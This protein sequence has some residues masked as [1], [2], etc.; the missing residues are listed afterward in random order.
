VKIKS[1]RENPA[2]IRHVLKTIS[3]RV[4]GTLITI[5]TAYSLGASLKLSSIL[6]TAEILIKPIF[7]FLHERVWYKFI[8]IDKK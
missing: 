3:Y 2:L 8:R 7:Y 1:I 4:L 6:G 5:V